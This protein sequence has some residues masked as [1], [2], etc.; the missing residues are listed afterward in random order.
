MNDLYKIV[1]PSRIEKEYS[2]VWMENH[3]ELYTAA[4]EKMF[5]EYPS[6]KFDIRVDNKAMP[7]MFLRYVITPRA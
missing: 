7:G 3:P 5:A 1:P 2:K 6:D 4:I